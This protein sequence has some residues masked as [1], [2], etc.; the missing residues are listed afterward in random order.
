M[1]YCSLFVPQTPYLLSV[2]EVW[3]QLQM[4][5][6]ADGN[7]SYALCIYDPTLGDFVFESEAEVNITFLKCVF[8]NIAL[9]HFLIRLPHIMYY[10][11][12]HL[13][14]QATLSIRDEVGNQLE[15]DL[16]VLTPKHIL[17]HPT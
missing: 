6:D 7:V 14:F 16:Q 2:S 15:A 13:L 10:Y 9:F 11:V 1:F 3:S 12:Y 4:V 17:T 8:H 5:N